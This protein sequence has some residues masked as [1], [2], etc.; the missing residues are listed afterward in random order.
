[1]AAD[2]REREPVWR[3]DRARSMRLCRDTLRQPRMALHMADDGEQ[4][5][6]LRVA[7]RAE[8]TDQAFRR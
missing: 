4:I 6:H 2:A 8:H 7:A 3:I 5:A 1:M